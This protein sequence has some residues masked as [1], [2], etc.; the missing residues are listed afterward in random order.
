ME[1]DISSNNAKIK[2]FI[3]SLMP[4]IVDQVG[5]TN[6]RKALL[7]QVENDIGSGFEGSTMN[8]EFADCMLVLLKAPSRLTAKN[9]INLATT[10]SHEMVHVRQ[11]AKGQLKYLA[12]GARIWMGKTY[13]AD[14]PYLEQPWEID[15]FSRQEL[16][17][18]RAIEI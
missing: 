7:I 15:A 17:V 14:T 1:Y 3:A 16:I 12:N 6:S 13:A 9:F 11:L 10:L 18:R 5:L 8:I 4:S 2:K